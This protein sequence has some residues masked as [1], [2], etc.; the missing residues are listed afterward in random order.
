[1]VKFAFFLLNKIFKKTD[2]GRGLLIVKLGFLAP[3]EERLFEG[4]EYPNSILEFYWTF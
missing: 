3:F 1:M 2:L 4:K